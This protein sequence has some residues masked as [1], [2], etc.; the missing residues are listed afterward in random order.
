MENLH[1]DACS[2]FDG[3]VDEPWKEL[4]YQCHK[5]VR[6]SVAENKHQIY[7][8]DPDFRGTGPWFDWCVKKWQL[9][10]NAEY[11][12]C[13]ILTIFQKMVKKDDNEWTSIDNQWYVLIHSCG[14]APVLDWRVAKRWSLEYDDEGEA[15]TY[16][17]ELSEMTKSTLVYQEYGSD[18]QRYLKNMDDE[19]RLCLEILDWETHWVERFVGDSWDIDPISTS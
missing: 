11:V 10:D 18:F 6:L 1:R 3:L 7:R 15:L 2:S 17:L 9:N 12:P 13:K 8:A 5:E 4:A 19:Q 16:M 14:E